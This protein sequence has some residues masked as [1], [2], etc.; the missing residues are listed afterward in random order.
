VAAPALLLVPPSLA[1]LAVLL[2]LAALLVLAL[3]LALLGELR[4]RACSSLDVRSTTT[5]SP[6]TN[7]HASPRQTGCCSM[8]ALAVPWSRTALEIC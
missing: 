1:V 8:P 5:T 3:L 7:P 6:T 2:V 4:P